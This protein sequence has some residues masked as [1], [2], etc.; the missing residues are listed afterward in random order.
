M[1]HI[2]RLVRRCQ[3][4][5][6]RVGFAGLS[7]ALVLTALPGTA[8][9]ASGAVTPLLDCYTLSNG[10]YTLVFGYTNTGASTTIP[11]G[12]FNQIAPAALQGKQPTSFAAG[13]RH[14]VFTLK[15]AQ[16]DVNG[17]YWFLD[18]NTYVFYYGVSVPSAACPAGTSLPSSGN[19]TGGAIALLPSG[20]LDALLVRRAVLRVGEPRPAGVERTGDQAG[21]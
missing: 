19:G 6:L 15:I 11:I 20:V 7:A 9:A 5:A 13:T 10:I 12:S 2:P 1:R 21:G 14:G 18:Y 3:R 16:S 17:G 4:T 8:T